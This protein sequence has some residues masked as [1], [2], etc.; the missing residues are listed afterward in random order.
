MKHIWSQRDQD[1]LIEL[2]CK[3]GYPEEL[4]YV[5]RRDLGISGGKTEKDRP[6]LAYLISLVE[7][8]KVESLWTVETK[9]I[10][11]DPGY[12]NADRLALLLRE[13]RVA[14]CTPRQV[15]N[16]ANE[17]DWD[18]FH[19]EMIDS[20]KDNRY[21]TEKFSRTRMAKARCGYWCGTPVPGGYIVR[22]GDRDSYDII[23]PYQD[24]AL[25]VDKIF[26]AY[27][28]AQGSA[29]KAAHLLSGIEFPSF[30]EELKYMETRTSLRR[31]PRT[32]TGY[33]ITPSLINHIVQNPFYIGWWVY[34]GELISKHHHPTITGEAKFWQTCELAMTK[35]KRRGKAINF[36]TLPLNTLLWCANHG[37]ERRIAAHGAEGRYV[38]D[39][40]YQRGLSNHI[41]LDINHEFLDKPIIEEV[42]R[43]LKS[44]GLL[45]ELKEDVVENLRLEINDSRSEQRKLRA[46]I[47][48]LQQRRENYK[49]QLGETK[50]PGRVETYW[51]QIHACDEQISLEEEQLSQAQ[52]EELSKEDIVSV[53]NFLKQIRERWDKQ[54]YSLQ[55]QLLRQLLDKVVI[56]QAEQEIEA[57][58]Y[59]HTGIQQQLWIRR[60]QVNSG[61]DKKWNNEED[62]LL[63]V[64]WS[65]MS[66]EI[67]MA[68]LPGRSWMAISL[69]AH[70]LAL[71]RI[72]VRS[73]TPDKWRRWTPE[74]DEELVRSYQAGVPLEEIAD[75]LGR[76]KDAIECRASLKKL[77]R[78]GIPARSKGVEWENLDE[79]VGRLEPKKFIDNK[80]QCRGR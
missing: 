11:R 4:I 9:R 78:C 44:S 50:D 79:R 16:L 80:A 26:D 63:K 36:E 55:N 34:G 14:I 8:D 1:D 73:I 5:E 21:R 24:H 42:F 41:C 62:T 49:W 10:Y 57:V 51:E 25:V 22:K 61:R 71:K 28:E 37:V 39:Y 17:N 27:V 76:S 43:A 66:K 56:K 40:D 30:P 48:D 20:V 7:Q 47:K 38:C 67:I 60:P 68:A 46:D 33:R 69:R 77:K 54:P 45:L 58:I 13:H 31:S 70:R 59:W 35:G 6:G 19:E 23:E 15:F 2:A 75:K 32:A 52:E 64:L 12:I 74:E 3:D 72:K 18:D 65:S 53:I 29:L